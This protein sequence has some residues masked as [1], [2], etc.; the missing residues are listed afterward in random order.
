MVPTAHQQNV[1]VE[2]PYCD[3]N[4]LLYVDNKPTDEAT[5]R[6]IG[7]I[8]DKYIVGSYVRPCPIHWSPTS[9]ALTSG[10]SPPESV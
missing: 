1:A 4:S 5:D 7:K 6:V 8:N 2:G 9:L 10:A 3:M